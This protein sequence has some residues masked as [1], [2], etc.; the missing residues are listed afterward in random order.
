MKRKRILLIPILA[1][2][3]QTAC[4]GGWPT[5]LRTAL[6]ASP[7]FIGSLNLGDRREAVINDFTEIGGDVADF[8]DDLNACNKDKPCSLEAVNK[9]QTKFWDVLRHGNFKLRPKLERI[10]DLITGIIDAAKIFFGERQNVTA[11]SSA[12]VVTEEDL[13]ARISDLKLAMQP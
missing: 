5:L 2:L 7:A 10:Q 12:R 11:G 6:V 13:K 4:G 1:I 8:A 9:F 3:I